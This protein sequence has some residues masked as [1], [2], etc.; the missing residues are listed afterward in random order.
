M[1]QFLAIIH[2]R[3]FLEKPTI[4]LLRHALYC[5]T[6]LASVRH[7][8]PT[9]FLWFQAFSLK[10][11]WSVSTADFGHQSVQKNLLWQFLTEPVI[12]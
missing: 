12:Q 10:V 9:V 5:P 8:D 7:A 1:I 6:F 2:G 3:T 11:E 4:G